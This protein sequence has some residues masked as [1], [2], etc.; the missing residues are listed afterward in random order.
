MELRT[1]L[2]R[3]S[4]SRACS[5]DSQ[6]SQGSLGQGATQNSPTHAYENLN[7]DHI[8]KL[9]SKGNL[10]KVSWS[11]LVPKLFLKPCYVLPVEK[12]C[13]GIVLCYVFPQISPI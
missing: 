11:I 6:S 3:T 5:L 9:T 4:P 12:F 1:S 7:M 10:F 13:C 8:A 2:V